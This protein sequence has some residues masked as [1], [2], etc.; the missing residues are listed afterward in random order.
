MTVYPV[1]LLV[2]SVLPLGQKGIPS[3]ID[4][5]PVT[6]PLYI[7]RSGIEGDA[8]GDHRHHGGQDKAVHH[9]PFEHYA[10]WRAEIGSRDVLERPGAFG[11]NLSTSSLTEETVALGDVFRLGRV[12]LQISQGRQPC[13]K[14]N[15]RFGIPDMARRVQTTRRTGWYHRVLQEGIVTPGDEL[16]LVDRPLPDWPIA[17]LLNI[18]YADALNREELSA[19]AALDILPESWRSLALRRLESGRFEDWERR[20]SG[21]S[22]RTA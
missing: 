21:G 22:G 14:L 3:G 13:F 1:T 7:S 8:Q 10:A 19:M 16:V 6:L 15:L 12:L 20:L 4:K 5:H 17:R 18:L 2:G 9:Y 11:E